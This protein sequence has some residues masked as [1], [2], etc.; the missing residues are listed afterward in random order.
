MKKLPIE[1][2]VL[3]KHKKMKRTYLFKMLGG[4]AL[5]TVLPN[6]KA[7]QGGWLRNSVG[8][9]LHNTA[10]GLTTGAAQGLADWAVKGNSKYFFQSVVGGALSGGARTIAMNAIFGAPYIPNDL[11]AQENGLYRSGGFMSFINKILG[12]TSGVVLGNNIGFSS[13]QN[14][15]IKYHE[16]AHILQLLNN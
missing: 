11:F 10:R 13:E 8:E 3:V 1:Q 15:E 12:R 6:Y 9:T 4:M 7:T 16:Y 5:G 2:N 14:E